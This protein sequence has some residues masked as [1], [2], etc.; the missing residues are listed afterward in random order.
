MRIR[1][2]DYDAAWKEIVRFLFRPLMLLCFPDI[3]AQIDW[4]VAIEFLETE[5][6]S[7]APRSKSRRRRVD[8]LVRVRYLNGQLQRIL[9]HLEVQSQPDAEF[10]MRMFQYFYRLFDTYES[11]IVSLAILADADPDYRPEVFEL[12][13]SGKK[14]QFDYHRCKLLDFTDEFLEQSDNP[15]AK[16]ILAHRIAQR[17]MQDPNQRKALKLAWVREL[18]RFNFKEEEIRLLLKALDAMTP[19][20]EDLS[21]EFRDELIQT[22]PKTMKPYITSFER[23]ARKEALA[24]GRTE[25]RVEGRTEGI[26]EGQLLALRES[27]R[28]LFEERFGFLPV[29]VGSRLEMESDPKV[30]KAWNRRVATIETPEAFLVLLGVSRQA[31]S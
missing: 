10:S 3:A 29:G 8:T 4:S 21:I 30:L 17:T 20:P 22:D 7:I 11:P 1:R 2:S 15:V 19:L 24:Q 9:I 13:G 5:L 25:G 26:T 28:D 12:D 14:C 18:F 31:E 16:A 23:I 27:I 6:Q